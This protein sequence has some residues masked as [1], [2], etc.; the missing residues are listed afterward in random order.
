MNHYIITD[1][2]YEIW[3]KF[4]ASKP[5]RRFQISEGPKKNMS[6]VRIY[7]PSKKPG[8]ILKIDD[9]EILHKIKDVLAL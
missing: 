7:I 8:V 3:Q 4:I 9:R 1:G 2:G 6:K 5:Y